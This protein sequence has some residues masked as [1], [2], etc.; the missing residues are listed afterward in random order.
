[1]ILGRLAPRATI[2]IVDPPAGRRQPGPDVRRRRNV[3]RRRARASPAAS[4]GLLVRPRGDADLHRRR[5]GRRR[6][7]RDV[8]DRPRR[9]D[10]RAGP[11]AGRHRDRRAS[12][13]GPGQAAG[14]GAAAI[15][16]GPSGTT[17]VA[18]TDLTAAGTPRGA[19]HPAQARRHAG[20]ALRQPAA[21]RGS[22]APAARSGSRRWSAT[23][24][25][26]SC[27]PAPASRRT[28]MVV[29]LRANGAP[30]HELRQRRPDLPA[31]RPPARRRPDLHDA[32]TRSTPPAPRAD[33]RRLGRRPG[34]AG[35]RRRRRHGL[36]RPLRAHRLAIAADPLVEP[37]HVRFVLGLHQHD[38]AGRARRR[39]PSRRPG[40]RRRRRAPSIRSVLQE[41]R[42]VGRSSRRRAR[43][44]W[45]RRSPT[46]AAR[47]GK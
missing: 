31:A 10:R 2:P 24:P 23:A 34:R 12:R 16:Q 4:T 39:R 5:R 25:A 43:A 21:S 6:V 9:A 27:S 20:H 11:G 8:H 33:H 37:G 18:G 28:R 36:H 1:M 46:R 26:G 19:V 3:R 40:A 41:D 7:S 42:V 30:R 44:R 29:R 35:P 38:C 17:L 15:R 32:S 45:R 47:V 22:R 14:I 13:S